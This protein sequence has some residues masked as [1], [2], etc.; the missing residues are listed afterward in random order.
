MATISEF[1]QE[2]KKAAAALDT[3]QETTAKVNDLA[4]QLG[5]KA[6]QLSAKS[7]EALM[8]LRKAAEDYK[9]PFAQCLKQYQ[10]KPENKSKI[11]IK[12][13]IKWHNDEEDTPEFEEFLIAEEG[14]W[15]L[16]AYKEAGNYYWSVEN[17]DAILKEGGPLKSMKLAQEAAEKAL[18]SK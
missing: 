1:E 9:L 4:N 15:I 18:S 12:A 14:C 13:S 8:K 5:I 7:E 17:D 6:G 11:S 2:L 16:T 3:Y 10:V